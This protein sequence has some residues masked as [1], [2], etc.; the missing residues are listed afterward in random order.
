M[1]TPA[2]MSS[3]VLQFSLEGDEEPG[4][5]GVAG[6][7]GCDGVLGSPGV[8]GRDGKTGTLGMKGD[9]GPQ[10]LPVPYSGWGGGGGGYLCV[11]GRTTCP[12]TEK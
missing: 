10:Q 6:R 9:T 7:D 11:V 3:L 2:V 8:S 1:I 4:S 5:Q 12:Y